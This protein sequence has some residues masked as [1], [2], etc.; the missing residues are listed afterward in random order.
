M[1]H[2]VL[3]LVESASQNTYNPKVDSEVNS[4]PLV[5][6]IYFQQSQRNIEKPV[7]KGLL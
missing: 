5:T 7:E 3:T 6:S 1:D 4:I 2:T